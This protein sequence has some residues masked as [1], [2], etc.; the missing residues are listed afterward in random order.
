VADP[1]TDSLE[2]RAR[3]GREA[4][5]SGVLVVDEPGRQRSKTKR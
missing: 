4:L 1:A 3:S 2:L 5:L